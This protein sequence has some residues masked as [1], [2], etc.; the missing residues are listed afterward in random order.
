MIEARRPDIVL[1]DKRSKEVKII[2]VPG[3]S[4]VKEKEMEKIDKYQMLREEVRCMWQVNNV[5]MIPVVVGALGVISDNFER[6]IKKLDV[7]IAME[8]IQKTGLIGT[9][10]LFRKVLSL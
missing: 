3:G 6:Y 7:K 4:R 1:V 5:T 10:V 2:P 8:V 9:A